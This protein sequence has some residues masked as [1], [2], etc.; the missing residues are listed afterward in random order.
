MRSLERRVDR[1]EEKIL[2]PD[3]GHT[4]AFLVDA[5]EEEAANKRKEFDECPQCRK[6][7]RPLIVNLLHFGKDKE[8]AKP[9]HQAKSDLKTD[10][11]SYPLPPGEVEPEAEESKPEI[12][13]RFLNF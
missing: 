9:D 1:L 12:R 8:E 2:V 4:M 5:T 7:G 6:G 13:I 10:L 11:E 3:C